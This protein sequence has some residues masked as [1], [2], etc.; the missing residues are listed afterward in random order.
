MSRPESSPVIRSGLPLPLIWL[1]FGISVKAKDTVLSDSLW[2]Q[3]G[4][5]TVSEERQPKSHTRLGGFSAATQND[6]YQ[7]DQAN[8]AL[9]SRATCFTAEDTRCGPAGAS[10]HS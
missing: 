9:V 4:S 7:L 6:G 10:F 3:C 1:R 2:Q 8:R 5:E